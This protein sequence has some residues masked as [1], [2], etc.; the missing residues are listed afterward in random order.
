MAPFLF[1]TEEI[2]TSVITGTLEEYIPRDTFTVA[3]AIGR[4]AGFDFARFKAAMAMGY[5]TPASQLTVEAVPP[6]LLFIDTVNGVAKWNPNR[7]VVARDVE[8]EWAFM[9]SLSGHVG[10]LPDA[11]LK[12]I[13]DR[14]F[15]ARVANVQRS[16]IDYPTTAAPINYQQL[17]HVLC[18]P[19]N[20]KKHRRATKDETL[21]RFHRGQGGTGHY[22]SMSIQFSSIKLETILSMFVERFRFR[23][24]PVGRT[25]IT[26]LPTM[27]VPDALVSVKSD[28]KVHTRGLLLPDPDGRAT[29]DRN[30]TELPMLAGSFMDLELNDDGA[31]DADNGGL[32]PRLLEPIQTSI[33]RHFYALYYQRLPVDVT[34]TISEAQARETLL[35]KGAGDDRYGV[36]S[37]SGDE[38]L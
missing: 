9:K 29:H 38:V 27:T 22:V 11:L 24:T 35:G 30:P 37:Y 15:E 36:R 20:K 4:R 1:C 10:N 12:K 14:L 26:G 19:K 32:G 18:T 2:A 31:Q 34:N 6:S 25:L 16:S 28:R 17:A 33:D 23:G 8:S 13:V 21:L 7:I 3:E 5:G